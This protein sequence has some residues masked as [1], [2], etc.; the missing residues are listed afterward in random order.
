MIHMLTFQNNS[1]LRVPN[2]IVNKY[3][4]RA[5]ISKKNCFIYIIN[6]N[7]WRMLNE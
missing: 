4:E 6:E 7:N 2:Y 3:V 1:Y 5:Y